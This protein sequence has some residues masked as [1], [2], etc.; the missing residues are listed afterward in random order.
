MCF[1]GARYASPIGILRPVRMVYLGGLVSTVGLQPA[2]VR[3]PMPR[4]RRVEMKDSIANMCLPAG[5]TSLRARA[6]FYRTAILGGLC[7]MAAVLA[8]PVARA[9]AT[10]QT[11]TYTGGEQTFTVPAG[12]TSVEVLATGGHGG[13][14]A[15]AGGFAAQVTGTLSVTSGRAGRPGSR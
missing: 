15:A 12:I 2:M 7:A 1:L 6:G 13:S 11:F 9:Q 10:T 8:A 4:K 14:A 3:L 5:V